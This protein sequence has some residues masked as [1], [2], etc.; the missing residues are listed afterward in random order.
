MCLISCG[1]HEAK[2]PDNIVVKADDLNDASGIELD[3]FTKLFHK[4]TR[5]ASERSVCR[6]ASFLITV[7]YG[8]QDKDF[9]CVIGRG[10][11]TVFQGVSRKKTYPFPAPAVFYGSIRN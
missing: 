2:K 11:P 7:V 9:V 5:L 8:F 4:C 3:I 6:H 1:I 10:W